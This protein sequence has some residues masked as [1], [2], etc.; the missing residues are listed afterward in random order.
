MDKSSSKSGRFGL[1]AESTEGLV[2]DGGGTV[3]SKR[4][5]KK[6]DGKEE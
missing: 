2:S 1:S 3:N 5:T 6:E 4:R